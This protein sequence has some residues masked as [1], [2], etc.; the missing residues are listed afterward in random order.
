MRSNGG[1][2]RTLQRKAQQLR[3][4]P[5]KR[6]PSIPTS[7]APRKRDLDEFDFPATKRDFIISSRPVSVGRTWTEVSLYPLYLTGASNGQQTITT[8]FDDKII[9][10]PFPRIL[11]EG[12]DQR[13]YFRALKTKITKEGS[14]FL[15]PILRRKKE[16]FPL[17]ALSEFSQRAG[18]KQNHFNT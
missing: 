12:R 11:A 16:K 13:R 2:V 9:T 17:T 8:S 4:P 18:P 7:R 1:D 5:D 6:K 10:L 14:C 15:F 3:C